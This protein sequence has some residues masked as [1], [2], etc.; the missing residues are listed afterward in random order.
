MQPDDDKTDKRSRTV[1]FIVAAA[2]FM[3]T[4][5][6]S[7]ITTAL[8][9]IGASFGTT[10]LDAS[11][12]ITA[13]LVAMAVCVPAAGWGAQRFGARRVFAAAVG[14]FT[15][16]SLL[17]A[18]AP[19]LW[20]FVAARVLQGAAAAFMS[21]VGRLVVLHETPKDRLIQAIGT[22]TWPGLIGPVLG[23]PLGG[24]IV[25]YTSWRWIFLLNVPLG[26]LGIWLILKYIPR[27]AAEG[28]RAF[29]GLGFVLTAFALAL[30]VQGL[31]QLGEH[32]GGLPAASMVALGAACAVAAVWHARRATAP[33]LDLRAVKVRTFAY[34]VV[35]VGFASRIAISASP[36]LLP[37]MFQIG[38]GLTALQASVALLTY[39]AGNLVMKSATT[40]LLTRY[41]F[42]TVLTVNSTLCAASIAACGLLSPGTPWALIY[43]VLL[44]TGM[45][46]SMNFTAISALTFAD[47]PPEQRAGASALSTML[48][49]MAMTLGVA[50]AAF[51]LSVSQGWRGAPVLELVDFRN[52][53]FAT[54]LLM[55]V[56]AICAWRLPRDTGSAV[57]PGR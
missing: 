24:L 39:M 48:Q 37:L 6:G 51:G 12:G 33:M 5:D 4:L 31:T 23:P 32:H 35:T 57:A 9:A 54:A 14:M 46:R 36:F 13:Y 17:C 29:D 30:L 3:E 7:V 45:T 25:T 55:A 1:P 15:F 56:A 20:T 2:F 50:L 11:V 8:P 41:G 22:I 47:V 28:K 44:I 19:G 27:R 38:F 34:S 16:A 21:P 18:I 49:L 42:R 52:V 43:P 53:W 10:A 26:L 40:M